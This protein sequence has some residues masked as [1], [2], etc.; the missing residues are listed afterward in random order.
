M[1][2]ELLQK[3]SKISLRERVRKA[4]EFFNVKELL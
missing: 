2:D 1:I 3:G 4:K